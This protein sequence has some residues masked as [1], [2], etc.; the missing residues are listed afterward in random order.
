MP[1]SPSHGTGYEV[2]LYHDKSWIDWDNLLDHIYILDMMNIYNY[3]LLI[4]Y[5]YIL[6]IIYI[7]DIHNLH[8]DICI[9]CIFL[10]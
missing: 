9:L 6:Y 4:I 3:N 7:Y 5:I 10:Q 1:V 8:V 2:N